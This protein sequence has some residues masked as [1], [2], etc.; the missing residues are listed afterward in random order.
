VRVYTG[1]C[2]AGRGAVVRGQ[3]SATSIAGVVGRTVMVTSVRAEA[4][5]L[6]RVRGRVEG[7][8]GVAERTA[9]E[10]RAATDRT[11]EAV[12]E[13]RVRKATPTTGRREAE[14]RCIRNCAR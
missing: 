3:R 9:R 2:T 1:R 8:N 4:E 10:R 5:A 11:T 13:E 7:R 14:T 12:D 6:R